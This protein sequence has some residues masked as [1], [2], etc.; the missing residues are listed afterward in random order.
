MNST[1]FAGYPF[2]T[3]I[4]EYPLA[5]ENTSFS[6]TIDLTMTEDQYLD[7]FHK[8]DV[9]GE[10]DLR[11]DLYAKWFQDVMQDEYWLSKFKKE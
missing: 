11:C 4:D 7:I 6:A 5:R 9:Y 1:Y 8:S 10:P 3:D 2:H